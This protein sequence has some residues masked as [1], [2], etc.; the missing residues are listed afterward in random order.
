MAFFFIHDKSTKEQQAA[1]TPFLSTITPVIKNS[2]NWLTGAYIALLNLPIVILGSL[3]G[4]LYLTQAKSLPEPQAATMI[5]LLFISAI[6]GSPLLSW[7]ATISEKSIKIMQASAL[8]CLASIILLML[9]SISSTY[10]TAP[11]IILLGLFSSAQVLGYPLIVKSNHEA[12]KATALGLSSI[13]VMSGGALIRPLYGW[14]IELSSQT[15]SG[16]ITTYSHTYAMCLLPA[17]FLLA[18][19]LSLRSEHTL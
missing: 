9:P 2:Q 16:E 6:I 14:I 15:T 10:F 18:F 17:A 8:I 19:F 3:W 11:L 7:L 5:S 1:K 13:L 4:I 12:V